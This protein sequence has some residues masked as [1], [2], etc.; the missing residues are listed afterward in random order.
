MSDMTINNYD[1]YDNFFLLH[2]TL[3][4]DKFEG[5]DFKYDSR[6]FK[7]QSKV[8]QIRQFWFQILILFIYYET[9]RIDKF[10]GAN[11]K[12]DNNFLKIWLKSTQ[13]RQF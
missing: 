4:L 11:F 10:E 12:Y 3:H 5:V 9:L 7:S 2:E 8:T 1:K 6:L 13:K